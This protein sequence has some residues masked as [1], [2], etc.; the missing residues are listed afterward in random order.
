MDKKT[1][2][3][4]GGVAGVAAVFYII[5]NLTPKK[6]I[7]IPSSSAPKTAILSADGNTQT[8]NASL[9]R[10]PNGHIIGAYREQ[11]MYDNGVLARAYLN[12]ISQGVEYYGGNNESVF[13]KQD[14]YDWYDPNEQDT[15]DKIY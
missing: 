14:S 5:K 10:R 1:K 4:I 2:Y 15:T 11:N 7:A 6:P 9:N 12:L 13:A 8:T 3:I